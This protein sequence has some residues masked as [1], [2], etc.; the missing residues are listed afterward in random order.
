MASV[1]YIDVCDSNGQVLN[2]FPDL[3]IGSGNIEETDI[4]AAEV[5]NANGNRIADYITTKISIQC[6][7]PPLSAQEW[8]SIVTYL[9][10]NK[11][12][13][14]KYYDPFTKGLKVMKAYA[15]DR[16]ATPNIVSL[17]TA[18]PEFYTGCSFSINEV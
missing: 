17:E 5:Y 9:K 4:Y 14:V 3:A 15:S 18:E 11:T 6:S 1:K 13:F 7:F 2:I 10:N 8:H 12:F 16:R